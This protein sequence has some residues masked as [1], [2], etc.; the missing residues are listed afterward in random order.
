[1]LKVRIQYILY[2]QLI[3]LYFCLFPLFN[4]ELIIFNV[5]YIITLIIALWNYKFILTVEESNY[6]KNIIDDVTI[7]KNEIN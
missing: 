5:F 7:N 4:Q 6:Y 3:V 1:M 2:L